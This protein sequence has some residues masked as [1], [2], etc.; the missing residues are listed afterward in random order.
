M[1]VA[2]VGMH[3]TSLKEKGSTLKLLQ[4]YSFGYH[5]NKPLNLCK[6][7]GKVHPRTGHE[8]LERK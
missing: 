3:M 2:S 4:D 8:S 6:V 1:E 7:T 5:S